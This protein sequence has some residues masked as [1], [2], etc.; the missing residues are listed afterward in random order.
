MNIVLFGPPGAGKGTQ[1][2]LLE[3][4]YGL[5]HLSTGEML[6]A[7]VRNGTPLGQKVEALLKNGDLVPD[8]IIIDIIRG[9]MTG[10]DCEG[11]PEEDSCQNGF[12]LDGFPRTVPQA[13]A[14]E[15]MLA[16]HGE[17][18]DHV[19][20]LV[21]DEDILIERIHKRME[22]TGVAR[23][24]DNE[25]TL[26]HRLSVYHKQTEPILPYFEQKGL[27]RKI[28]GM[29]PIEEVTARIAAILEEGLAQPLEK[30]Q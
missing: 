27:L 7:E 4:N 19:I 14:L 17:K 20:V 11:C 15:K 10:Q 24:D 6:R 30:A 26:R 3:R 22:E 13:E 28:D 9:C 21:V 25:E 18:V 2:H 29:L 5:K 8:G 16:E 12:I 23:S 1:A